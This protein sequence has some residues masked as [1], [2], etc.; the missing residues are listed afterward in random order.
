[1]GLDIERIQED[2][3]LV[4]QAPPPERAVDLALERLYLAF[5]D[6]L[7][8]VRLLRDG[9]R[10]QIGDRI[11]EIIMAEFKAGECTPPGSCCTYRIDC[12][13][14]EPAVG[15]L[16]LVLG[17]MAPKHCDTGARM[18]NATLVDMIREFLK[19]QE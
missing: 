6:L 15:L 1:M 2:W 13:D 3:D 9:M 11:T 14:N 4:D 12:D 16:R 17:G 10:K 19:A 8:E 5:P 18:V 7:A